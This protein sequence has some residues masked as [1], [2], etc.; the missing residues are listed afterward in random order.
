M[1]A[2]RSSLFTI[3][4]AGSGPLTA[5][6]ALTDTALVI[7]LFGSG[8]NISNENPSV[9]SSVT[10][11]DVSAIILNEVQKSLSNSSSWMEVLVESY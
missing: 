10:Y 7:T 4:V 1:R 11:D 8:W 9:K 3:A 5:G 6:L 2:D